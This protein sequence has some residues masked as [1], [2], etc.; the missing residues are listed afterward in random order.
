MKTKLS[1]AEVEV[2]R[3][4]KNLLN[5]F[6]DENRQ[7]KQK[8]ASREREDLAAKC[9]QGLEERGCAGSIEGATSREKIATLLGRE[10]LDSLEGMIELL[11]QQ[12]S[13]FE[14]A[15]RPGNMSSGQAAEA[16]LL[17]FLHT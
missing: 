1:A 9:L 2:I 17:T 12:G 16:N 7:L 4:A 6:R 10:D 3:D 11:P 15:D 13:S 14:L 8:L 5:S